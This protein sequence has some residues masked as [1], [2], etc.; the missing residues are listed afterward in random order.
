MRFP[1]SFAFNASKSIRKYIREIFQEY[2]IQ[3]KM[4][5]KC[6]GKVFI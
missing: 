6:V 2:S 4:T 3:S 1:I 5:L